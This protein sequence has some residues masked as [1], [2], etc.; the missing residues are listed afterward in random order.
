MRRTGFAR[1]DGF[2]VHPRLTAR[3]GWVPPASRWAAAKARAVERIV[4]AGALRIHRGLTRAVVALGCPAVC[5]GVK[6]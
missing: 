3:F 4:P 2:V 1:V 5:V 6:G